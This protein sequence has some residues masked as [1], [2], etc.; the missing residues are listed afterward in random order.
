M[1]RDR[2]LY[3]LICFISEPNQFNNS[4]LLVI[5]NFNLKICH[6]VYRRDTSNYKLL[7]LLFDFKLFI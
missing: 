2:I 7:V 1:H 3:N 4:T 6:L 5:H